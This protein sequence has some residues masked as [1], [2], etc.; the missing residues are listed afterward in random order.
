MMW[1]YPAGWGWGWMLI[2]MLWMVVFWGAIIALA[3]WGVRT[4]VG[5]QPASQPND[6]VAIAERRYAA[7]EITREQLAEIRANLRK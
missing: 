3:V 7:G 4:L 2:G 6:A 1:G 5:R